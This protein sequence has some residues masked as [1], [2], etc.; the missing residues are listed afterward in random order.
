MYK[1]FKRLSFWATLT[2]VLV[3]ASCGEK[4]AI[5]QI[6]TSHGDIKV[7]LYNETPAHRDTFIALVKRGYYD[8]LHNCC[9]LAA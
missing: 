6:S 2:L 7:K 9:F 3:F 8:N 1:N 5:V 4:A